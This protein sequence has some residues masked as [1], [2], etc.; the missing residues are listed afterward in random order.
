M[1]YS[2]AQYKCMYKKS[3]KLMLLNKILLS[4]IENIEYFITS[5]TW[6]RVGQMCY[7]IP[8]T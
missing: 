2:H 3:H 5:C 4:L 1:L 6:K 7:D 8:I